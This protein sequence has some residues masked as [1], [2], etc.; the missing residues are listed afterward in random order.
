MAKADAKSSYVHYVPP[1]KK[2]PDWYKKYNFVLVTS[3]EQLE[4]IFKDS[5]WTPKRSFISFDTET[6][7]L[8]PEEL[9][10]VGYSF[11]IDGISTY[12]V[13][14]NH[15]TRWLRRRSIRFNL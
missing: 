2:I 13:P 6:T 15:S 12:Y 4:Q 7:G 10:I 3:M 8:N 5:N 14:V 9:D 1:A 11:C